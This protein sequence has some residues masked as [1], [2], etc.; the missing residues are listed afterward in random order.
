MAK[1]GCPSRCG[2]VIIPYPFGTGGDCNVTETFFITCNTSFTPN[3]PLLFTFNIK[4]INIS[5]DGQLRVLSRASYDCYNTR[6]YRRWLY[7]RLWLQLP[8]ISINNTK[9]RFTAIGC[10]TYAR[11]EGFLGQRYATGCLSLCNSITNVSNGCCSGIGC[12]QTSIPKGVMS[13][14]ITLESY[15]NHVDVLPENPCC[16]AFVAEND[17]YTFSSSDLRGF[18]FRNREFPV[19]PDWK[20]GTTSCDEAKIDTT[21]FGCKENS[22]CIDSKNNSG[23]FCKYINECETMSPCNGTA[24]C[25]NLLGT[26]NC[27]CPVG[28]EGDGR[29]NGTGCSLPYKDW[30]KRSTLIDV[31]L[32]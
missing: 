26:Y 2:D 18:G 19:T 10:D 24:R 8:G 29:K 30:S 11:V 1:P 22:D 28:Y 6:G 23:Y 31:A 3:K 7:Y 13:Y 9:N 17:N 27:S 15:E 21:N 4:V 14:N 12:C 5:L 25:I 32:G 20:I 16:Y